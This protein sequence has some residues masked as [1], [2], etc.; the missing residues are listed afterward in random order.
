MSPPPLSAAPYFDRE[1]LQEAYRLPYKEITFY[2]KAKNSKERQLPF[3]DLPY[4]CDYNEAQDG[5]NGDQRLISLDSHPQ[6]IVIGLHILAVDDEILAL[7]ALTAALEEALPEAVIYDFRFPSEALKLAGQV[8][9]DIA[10]L[11]I[12]MGGMNGLELARRLKEVDGKTKIVLVTGYFH[13]GVNSFSSAASGYLLK[14]IGAKDI[15]E[16]M[17]AQS[18]PQPFF[19]NGICIQTFGG[20]EVQVDGASLSF[21]HPSSKE[22]LA[23]LV[24]Q[25]GC[26]VGKKELAGILWPDQADNWARRR[27]LKETLTEMLRPLR[28]RG[29]EKILQR[30]RGD[31]RIRLDQV[32]C[33]YYRMLQWDVKAINRYQG[34][35][36]PEYRWAAMTTEGLPLQSSL[37]GRS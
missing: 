13:Y 3:L 25:K 22:A 29:A 33:D 28:E 30:S 15:L 27:Q 37:D 2:P 8:T 6:R 32:F 16:V 1:I 21:S 4:G 34:S 17:E 10:F 26:S 11:D 18:L 36:L 7:E 35:Y 24:H 20:F 23:Y 9:I 12:E 5:Q 31:Y 19:G 14:P